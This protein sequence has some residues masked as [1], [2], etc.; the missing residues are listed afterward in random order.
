MFIFFVVDGYFGGIY[1]IFDNVEGK[2]FA[3]A[4]KKRSEDYVATSY[5]NPNITSPVMIYT[6]DKQGNKIVDGKAMN[7]TMAAVQDIATTYK[8]RELGEGVNHEDF[9]ENALSAKMSTL[10]KVLLTL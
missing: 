6:V 4:L 9:I 3:E 7:T 8:N 1:D 10:S 5:K 2:S